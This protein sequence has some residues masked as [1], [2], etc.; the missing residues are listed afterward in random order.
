M[1]TNP[2]GQLTERSSQHPK[3]SPVSNEY[4]VLGQT[5]A[6]QPA[7]FAESLAPDVRDRRGEEYLVKERS[8]LLFGNIL[9]DLPVLGHIGLKR[10]NSVTD[11]F[12]AILDVNLAR[13]VLSVQQLCAVSRVIATIV[14][15]PDITP[16]VL[17]SG[18]RVKSENL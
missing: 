2:A 3:K 13:I 18:R 15:V 11:D 1:A 17:F 16:A 7:T 6:F 8:P 4:Q 9:A 14:I 5:D 12:R 10:E